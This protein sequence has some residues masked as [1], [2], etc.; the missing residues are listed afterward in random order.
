[1]VIINPYTKQVTIL[2]PLAIPITKNTIAV[3]SDINPIYFTK[4]ATSLY[5]VVD[6]ATVLAVV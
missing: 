1:M 3:K 6:I 2:A 5:N 4:P